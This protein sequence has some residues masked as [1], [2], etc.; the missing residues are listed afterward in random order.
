LQSWLNLLDSKEAELPEQ[1]QIVVID[2]PWEHRKGEDGHYIDVASKNA[3]ELA[4]KVAGNVDEL[5]PYLDKLLEGQQRQSYS[6]GLQLSRQLDNVDGLLKESYER[7][8]KI[9][10]YNLSFVLG[11]YGGILRSRLLFGMN[12]SQPLRRTVVCNRIIQR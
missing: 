1:L 7:L 8:F 2:P 6:F 3:M 11:I 12:M 10:N 4:T 5:I 9:D